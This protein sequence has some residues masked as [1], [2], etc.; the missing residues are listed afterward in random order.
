MDQKV[1]VRKRPLFKKESEKGD[2]DVIRDDN[3]QSLTVLEPKT[4]V[5]LTKFTEEHNFFF[6]EVLSDNT[7]N[8][9]VY[10]RCGSPL[11]RY[12]FEK[13]GKASCFAYGQTGSGKTHTMM[14]NP[15]QPGLYF[16]A[17]DEIFTL[18]KEKGYSDLTVWVSFF[19]IYGGKLYDLLNDR[20]KLVARADAKQ[21]V[22]IVGLQETEVKSVAHLMDALNVGHEARSTA[23]TGANLDSSRSHAVLQVGMYS[24]RSLHDLFKNLTQIQF[25]RMNKSVGKLSFIDLAGSERASDVN[26]NDRQ[27][28][29]EGAE[30]NKSLLALKECIRALDQGSKHV[31]FRGST[32]TSV[33]KDSFIGNCR[34]V[35]IANVSPGTS[36][37]EHTMNTLRYANRVKQLKS[38]DR[39]KDAYALKVSYF[40]RACGPSLLSWFAGCIHASSGCSPTRRRS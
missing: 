38:A 17:A 10:K 7:A 18:K 32:L 27:T 13:Q 4:K 39:G 37:C 6:D 26:D 19:E 20:R 24:K 28:R 29:I 3:N 15:E 36:A 21:V 5:D 33:L 25:K 12:V 2:V 35:M 40:P 16:L 34:T 8:K 11:V 23:A 31:P 1:C 14:G 9:E 22:N 30:I